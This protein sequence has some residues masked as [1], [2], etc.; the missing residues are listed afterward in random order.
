MTETTVDVTKAPAKILSI[1]EIKNG[2]V[3]LVT[4]EKTY[5]FSDGKWRPVTF[6]DV[7]AAAVEA[8][9]TPAKVGQVPS[10]PPPPKSVVPPPSANAQPPASANKPTTPP[11]N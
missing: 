6:A 8:S 11:S 7:E 10:A 2:A 3:F 9:S 4:E 1:T 5:Q